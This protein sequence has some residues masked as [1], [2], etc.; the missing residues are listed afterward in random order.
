MSMLE[1][2]I[3]S[4]MMVT[5]LAA[6]SVV[7]RTG[8]QAWEAHEADFSRIEAGHSMI[9][10]VV[11]RLRR[12][13]GVASISN[14]TDNSGRISLLMLDGTTWIW[15]HDANTNQ[16]N[17]GSSADPS[18]SLLATDIT[19]LSFRGFE[20]DGTTLTTNLADIQLIEVTVSIQLPR[21][22]GGGRTISSFAWLRA[23]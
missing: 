12:S 20:A 8:R 22:T 2:I 14:T 21:E 19:G 15:D 3:A 5:L 7:M 6:I 16:V 18:L 4:T 11:R 13:Q 9:R 10:H 1:L 23:W 17:Y